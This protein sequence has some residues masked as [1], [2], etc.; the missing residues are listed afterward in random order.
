L[1]SSNVP[2]NAVVVGVPARVLAHTGSDRLI[3]R[4]RAEV[5]KPVAPEVRR[6][7]SPAASTS[8]AGEK[9]GA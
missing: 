4:G 7:V 2:E 8:G 1:V 5:P 6:E 9:P 3:S